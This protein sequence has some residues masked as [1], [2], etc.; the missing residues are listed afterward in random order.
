[1]SEAAPAR[2]RLGFLDV[3]RGLAALIV[4]AEHALDACFPDLLRT[5]LGWGNLGRAGVLLFLLI[6]GF[7]I[8]ASL[9][10]GGSNGRFWL[11]R[12]FRLLPAYWLSIAAAYA[13][14]WRSGR[15]VPELPGGH[16]GDW[17][18]NLTMLQGF[19]DRPHVWG[20]FWTLQLELVIYLSCSLLFAAG[21]LRRTGWIAV[22]ALAGFAQAGLGLPLLGKT[23]FPVGDEHLLYFAPLVGLVAQRYWAGKLSRDR[24]LAL[25]LSQAILA[26]AV[27]W[28]NRRMFPQDITAACLRTLVITWGIAYA[29]FFL[30]LRARRRPMP[31]AGLWLG[32][33]SYSLYL[34]HPFVL[35]VL[36]QPG[37]PAW[38]FLPAF[39]ASSLVVAATAYRFVE[40]PGIA[41][42]RILERRWL[43][44]PARAAAALPAR[45]AA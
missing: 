42:G 39:L 34:L 16:A 17:L 19:L 12:F 23:P 15:F 18:L 27:A 9:E 2:E 44:V 1:M 26:A 8:P 10:Q 13:Y 38:L 6:S 21:L 36:V 29:C 37:W 41:L 22:L 11:R 33:I 24:L 32:R 28:V 5:L 30:L 35:V 3:A 43:P 31:R 7:I 20:I 45:R 40:T 25:G 4:L 14:C